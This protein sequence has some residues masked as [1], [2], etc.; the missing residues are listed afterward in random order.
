M[1]TGFSATVRRATQIL[2][3]PKSDRPLFGQTSTLAHRQPNARIGYSL[4]IRMALI[5][6]VLSSL[7]Y[8]LSGQPVTDPHPNRQIDLTE[9]LIVLFVD[10]LFVAP[11]LETSIFHFLYKLIFSQ[12]GKLTNRTRLIFYIILS[13]LI[14][15]VLHL[16]KR[17]HGIF[18]YHSFYQ[19]L[20]IGL[21]SGSIFSLTYYRSVNEYHFRPY[22]TTALCHALVN[23][24]LVIGLTLV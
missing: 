2:T 12:L 8:V 14:F 23:G 11:L 9:L 10:V 19:A 4:A 24:L 21:V 17:S 15:F 3:A 7:C 6:F 20:V 16:P 13:D 1:T 5:D 18:I 22:L